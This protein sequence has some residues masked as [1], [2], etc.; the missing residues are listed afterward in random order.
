MKH[1]R[2]IL[3]QLRFQRLIL[4]TLTLLQ[5]IAAMLHR[6]VSARHQRQ[7]FDVSLRW[8][9]TLIAKILV[10]RATQLAR[11]RSPKRSSF[12]RYGEDQHR[13]HILSSALGARLRRKLRHKDIATWLADL[14]AILRDLDTHA[15]PLATR[16]RHG[17]TRLWR[18]IPRI[19]A[20]TLIPGTPAPSRATSD[21]S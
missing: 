17:L 18:V 6:P 10:V 19:A 16:L 2:R 1:N 4:W 15:T 7:R 5:W 21:S 13:R 3:T 20:A 9:T 8:L 11:C 12:W 14:I